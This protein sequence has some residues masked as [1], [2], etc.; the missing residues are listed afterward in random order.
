MVRR[1]RINAYSGVRNAL[2]PSPS[3]SS[4]YWAA[5]FSSVATTST[6]EVQRNWSIGVTPG[7]PVAALDE[8][9]EIARQRQR[10]A[11][12]GRDLLHRRAGK[13]LALKLCGLQPARGGSKTTHHRA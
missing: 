11:A 5:Y 6:C 12:D 10:I 9:R 2:G 8:D 1:L 4:A 3:T 13:L 7:D